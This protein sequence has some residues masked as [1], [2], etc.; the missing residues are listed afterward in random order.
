MAA[1][2]LTGAAPSFGANTPDAKPAL[3]GTSAVLMD[4]TTG[5]VLYAKNADKKRDP[6]S[7]TKILNCL[8]TLENLDLD[9][10]VTAPSGLE[11]L[12]HIL[13]LKPGEE[14]NA[15]DLVYATMIYSGNDGAEAMAIATAGSIDRFCE[16]MNERAESIGARD[17]HFTNA[18]GMNNWGQENHRTTAYDLALITREALKNETFRDIVATKEYTVPATNKSKARKYKT[19]NALLYDEDEECKYEGEEFNYHYEGCTGVKTGSTGTAGEC[20]VGSA[21]RG[22]TEFI[23]VTLNASDVRDRYED[24]IKMLDYGFAHFR[25]A[26]FKRAG[27]T[28]DEIKVRHGAL[29]EVN[30]GVSED[31]AVTV[32]RKGPGARTQES[33]VKQKSELTANISLSDKAGGTDEKPFFTAPIKKGEVLGYCTVT[34]S[35]GTVFAKSDLVAL[36]D[37]EEGTILSYIGIADEEIPMAALI[38]A[39]VLTAAIILIVLLKRRRRKETEQ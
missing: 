7:V 20:F 4:A 38:A 21:K 16:M 15:R 1:L 32:L 37:V 3:S 26:T 36:E 12:G 24:A 8:V 11:P 23:A 31:L 35:E 29:A 19:T 25:T 27:K 30:V 10:T 22:N 33:V 6:A 5:T 9:S 2:I 34:D 39:A 14:I 28:I 13:K 17:T 18:T